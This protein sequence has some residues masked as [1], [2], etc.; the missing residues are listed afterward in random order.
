MGTGDTIT[1][2]RIVIAA[3]SRATVPDIVLESRVPYY[4]SDTVMR[5]DDVPKRVAILGGGYIAAEFAHI[6]SAF[7]ARAPRSSCAATR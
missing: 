6:F 4:T 5:I 2:D 1:A 7:G 3:G